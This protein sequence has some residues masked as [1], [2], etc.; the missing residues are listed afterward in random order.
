MPEIK[1]RD[2]EKLNLRIGKIKAVKQHPQTQDYS[3]LM[4]LGP[5]GRP[6]Q[7][8][9]DLHESYQMNVLMGKQVIYLQNLE[10]V[11]VQ[12]IESQGLILIT[13]LKGKPV[14]LQP[15]KKVYTGVKV[16]GLNNVEVG[17]EGK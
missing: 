9:V 3:V 13:H 8:V 4:Y 16:V 5:V 12:G 2:V 6:Q 15:E 14:L 17:Y 7:V 10:P 1:P 11:I